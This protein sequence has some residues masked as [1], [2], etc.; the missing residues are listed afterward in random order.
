[1]RPKYIGPTLT[2]G[3]G[4]QPG[5]IAMYITS[6]SQQFTHGA[7]GSR[8]VAMHYTNMIVHTEEKHLLLLAALGI[9]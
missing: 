7:R 3:R 2:R 5:D 8:A 6:V 9:I 1:M 4:G